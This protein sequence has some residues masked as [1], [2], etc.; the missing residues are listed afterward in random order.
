M[1]AGLGVSMESPQSGWMSLRLGALDAE[2]V[3]V[4]SCTPH[5]SLRDLI[6][7]LTA[8][9]SGE[10]SARVVWNAEPEEYDFLFEARGE[11]VGLSVVRHPDHRRAESESRE[12]FS[13]R[14][15][16]RELCE[17]FLSELE[18]LRGRSETDAFE[19]NWKRPFPRGE[20]QELS[21]KL[22]AAST[23]QGK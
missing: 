6:L 17:R 1:T 23:A 9:L 15:P 7:S 10:P 22:R 18:D 13:F 16:L 19:R 11:E 20:L 3:A 2:F 21:E 5:D 12:V 14:G 8:L 4:V